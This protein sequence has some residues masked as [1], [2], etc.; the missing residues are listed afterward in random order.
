[1]NEPEHE[2]IDEAVARIEALMSYRRRA[3]CDQPLTR[4]VSLPQLH[5]L[6]RLQESGPTMVSELAHALGT[7]IPSASSLVDR[8]EEHGLVD[9]IRNEIDR[10]VVHVAI[11]ERGQ[12]VV[13]EFGGPKR[14]QLQRLLGT[15]SSQELHDVIRGAEAV[16]RGLERLQTGATPPEETDDKEHRPY[17]ARFGS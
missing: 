5:V 2:L 15:M 12:A 9:R 8:M 16:R 1:V 10:R 4:E 13:E 6:M 3:F 7:S 14:V 17:I 11:S